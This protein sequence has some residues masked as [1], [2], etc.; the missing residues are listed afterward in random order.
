V[1]NTR[2]KVPKHLQVANEL[3]SM[4]RRSE[5]AV[6]SQLPPIRTLS[7]RL[8]VSS[9]AVQR[10]VRLLEKERVVECQHGVG[11]RVI[12]EEHTNRTPMCFGLVYPFPAGSSFAGAIHSF[13]E[14]A[15]DVS[16]NLC[17]VK[18]SEGNS[19]RERK[20]VE[21]LLNSG[22]EGL[23]VWP[24]AGDRNEAFL[25]RI[26][27]QVPLV[28]IDR[29][30]AGVRAPSVVLDWGAAGRDIARF[31]ARRGHRSILV[32]EDPLPISSY[33]EM[34]SA[35]RATITEMKAERR[36]F[37]EPL[38]TSVCV[39]RYP[40]D[41]CKI[42]GTYEKRLEGILTKRSYDAAFCVQ[43]GFL[44]WTYAGSGMAS[45]FPSLEWT[46]VCSRLSEPRSPAFY[47]LGARAWVAD[48][49]E[50]ICRASS[51]LHNMLHLRSKLQREIRVKFTSIVYERR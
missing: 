49:G 12:D 36:F 19:G 3:K 14:T 33:G 46:C 2:S 11:V 38:D 40:H 4:I 26:A 42:A 23:M 10:A 48:H 18:S 29:T 51:I 34:Y 7:G 1:I 25:V 27:E 37:L 39:E 20:V 32:L 13:A 47:R 17:I 50:M 5:F 24:C 44:D 15:T 30:L 6:G 45:R 16:R 22:I 28:T 43:E 35:I 8:G 21:Q 9:S 41:P 31:L